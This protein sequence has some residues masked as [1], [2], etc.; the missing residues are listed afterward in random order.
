MK[1]LPLAPGG[2]FWT[3]QGEGLMSGQP[4]V[5]IRLAGC[6]VGCPECD[7]DYSVG[8]RATVSEIAD[9]VAALTPQGGHVRWVWITGGEPL[10]HDLRP[11]VE[12]LRYRQFMV[13]LAT[14]GAKPL[15]FHPDFISLSPHS[16]RHD[17]IRSAN[18][19]KVVP[20]LNSFQPEDYLKHG[21][22][23]EVKYV[24]PLDGDPNSLQQCID[25]VLK[26]PEWRLTEQAHKRWRLP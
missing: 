9:R 11:L 21:P 8:A 6:S 4:M 23:G 24:Q 22:R 3:I 16:P 18:E 15:T 10:D 2:I 25:W 20:G 13:A 14:T 12:E 7:T 17:L 5:F 19:I 1:K 26:N